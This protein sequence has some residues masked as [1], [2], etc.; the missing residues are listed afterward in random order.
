MI[1]VP[2]ARFAFGVDRILIMA[3]FYLGGA[4]LYVS[5]VPERWFPGKFDI[6]VNFF[7]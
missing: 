5:R 1:K 7:L 6:W 4:Y 2:L 3:G